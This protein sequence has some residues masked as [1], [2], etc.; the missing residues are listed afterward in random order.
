MFCLFV[1]F[2]DYSF[3]YKIYDH[4]FNNTFNQRMRQGFSFNKY[5]L[6]DEKK[7]KETTSHKRR[8][9]W[10]SLLNRIWYF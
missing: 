2:V 5:S 10:A 1:Y 3:L 8:G 4:F 7:K 9:Y 6:I